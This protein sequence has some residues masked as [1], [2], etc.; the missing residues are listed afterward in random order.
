MKVVVWRVW[1][2]FRANG[3]EI[4]NT[5]ANN[6]DIDKWLRTPEYMEDCIPNRAV[7]SINSGKP[8]S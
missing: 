5:A 1:G 3:Q 4:R 7:V 8:L 2:V 6:N